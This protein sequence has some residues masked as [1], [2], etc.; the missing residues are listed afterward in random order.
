MLVPK[1]HCVD[2]PTHGLLNSNY[3]ERYFMIRET[4]T[5]ATGVWGNAPP[6]RKFQNLQV[7]KCNFQHFQADGCVKKVPKIDYL[8]LNLAKKIVAVS[9]IFKIYQLLSH[10]FYYML[11]KYDTSFFFTKNQKV[12]SD[13]HHDSNSKLIWISKIKRTN[14]MISFKKHVFLV[15]VS[16]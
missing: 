1:T 11:A 10:S 12:H 8:L 16:L 3:S 15:V 9:Y 7:L 13:L 4:L 5:S 6:P 14:S 2:C